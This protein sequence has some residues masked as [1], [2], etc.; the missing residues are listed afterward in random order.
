MYQYHCAPARPQQYHYTPPRPPPPYYLNPLPYPHHLTARSY[1]TRY[2][3]RSPYTVP[4]ST[5]ARTTEFQARPPIY[6]A[7][8][9]AS[10]E[11]VQTETWQDARPR[12]PRRSSLKKTVGRHVHFDLPGSNSGSRRREED[13]RERDKERDRERE[14]ERERTISRQTRSQLPRSRSSHQ[15]EKMAHAQTSTYEYEYDSSRHEE[16]YRT[17]ASKRPSYAHDRIETR[18]TSTPQPLFQSLVPIQPTIYIITYAA[19]TMRSKTAI[20]SLLSS[21]VPLRS[22]LIPH[23][24]TIDARSMTPPP[25]HLCAMY[26]GVSPLIQDVVMRDPAAAAAAKNAVRELLQFREQEKRQRR[27]QMEVSMSVCCHAGTHRSVAIAERIAQGVKG[28]V[29]RLGTAEGVRVVCR[30]VHRVKGVGDPF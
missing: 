11:P 3:Y 12:L 19:D 24:Y 8:T 18:L 27:P 14:R 25:P 16:R 20:T 22:P 1:D 21:Q 17:Y 23:L 13:A 10:R 26:S 7:H 6:H 15:P 4:T 2:M 5:P 30:H 28:E 9:A 29:G